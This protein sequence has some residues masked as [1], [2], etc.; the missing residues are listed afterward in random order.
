MML[1]SATRGGVTE[2]M[3][4]VHNDK[5]YQQK[6]SPPSW[7]PTTSSLQSASSSISS[8]PPLPKAGPSPKYPAY[9]INNDMLKS[10][11]QEL[12]KPDGNN[13]R[14]I[15]RRVDMKIP[16]KCT[17]DDEKEVALQ[18]PEPLHQESSTVPPVPPHQEPFVV[19]PAPPAPL[20][21]E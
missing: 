7:T 2:P 5:K 4:N 20:P 11:A 1:L 8:P 10:M 12:R 3:T 13:I 6:Y 14:K 9:S 15:P 17:N 16:N 19:P 18:S 21:L